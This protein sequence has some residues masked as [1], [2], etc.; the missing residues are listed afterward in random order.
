MNSSGKTALLHYWL[1][2]MRGGENVLAELCRHF[3]DA[4]IFTHAAIPE[5]LSPEITKHPIHESFVARLP[6]GRKHCRSYLPLMFSASRKWDLSPFDLIFS[7]ES[8]PAKA[9]RKPEQSKHI[10][11]CHT[12][13]RYLWD[14]YDEYYCSASLLGK[15]A[16]RLFRDSLREQDKRS[17]ECVDLFLANSRFVAERIKRIYG[18]DSEVIYPPVDVDFFSAAPARERTGFL[19]VGELV[20]YKRPDL[21]LDAFARLQ[22]EKLFVCGKGP[23]RRELEKRATPNVRFLDHVSREEL[24]ELYAGAKAL[25]FPGIEDFGIV[26]VEA[27][28]A[29]CP[30]IAMDRGGTAE[31]VLHGKTG[32]LMEQQTSAC[33]LNALEELSSLHFLPEDFKAQTAKFHGRNFHAGI[34]KALS[35]IVRG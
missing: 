32:L 34:E 21:V 9:I 31:T 14:M 19:F 27:M 28:A 18:R 4:E 8:G 13:M 11:Y 23:M 7:S 17:A 33:I 26:P 12:P 20:C 10:C 24:R 3:P 29:G 5:N 25:I 30:V 16:M 15:A 35:R 6:W 2:G 22:K 1:T